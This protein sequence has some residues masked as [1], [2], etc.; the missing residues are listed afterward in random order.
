MRIL[1]NRF[2]T[3]TP[4]MAGAAGFTLVEMCLVLIIVGLFIAGWVGYYKMYMKQRDMNTARDNTRLLASDI[5]YFRVIQDRYPCPARMDLPRTDFRFGHSFANTCTQTDIENG[6]CDPQDAICNPTVIPGLDPTALTPAS[7]WQ[8]AGG[9][10]LVLGTRDVTGDGVNDPVLIGAYPVRDMA[11]QT[12]RRSLTSPRGIGDEAGRNTALGYEQ[13]SMD[14]WGGQ[15]RYAVTLSLVRS[16]TF[17]FYQGTIAVRDEFGQPTAGIN[18][19]GHFVILS[20]GPN[21]RGAFLVQT[22][23]QPSPCGLDTDAADNENCDMDGVFTQGLFNYEADT[24]AFFDDVIR[25]GG[26]ETTLIW[27]RIPDAAGVPTENLRNLNTGN[28]GVGMIAET[29]ATGTLRTPTQKLDV[30]GVLR[31]SEASRAT[32]VCSHDGTANCFPIESIAGTGFQCPSGRVLK[33]IRGGGSINAPIQPVCV[34]PAFA[35]LI[36]RDC[37]PGKWVTGLKTDGQ[38]LCTGE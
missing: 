17:R 7:P 25:I 21:Q 14:P 8:C 6:A 1:L 24:P 33:Q 20:H 3:L 9:I 10:C 38:V 32:G 28:I 15:Y 30:S 23:T 4:R 2:R 27:D 31:S 5:S 29:Q 18:N 26:S 36:P 16:D 12:Q 13:D 37:G 35:P 22:G 19:D 11:L 34:T